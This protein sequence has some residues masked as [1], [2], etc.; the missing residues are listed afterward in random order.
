MTKTVVKSLFMLLVLALPACTGLVTPDVGSDHEFSMQFGGLKR[1]YDVHLPAGYDGKTALPVVIYLHGGGGNISG[2]RND[3]WIETAN[4]N[5]FI[6]VSP[7]GTGELPNRLL[8]WNAGQWAGGACCGWA[9]EHQVDDVGFVLTVIDEVS[10]AYSVDSQRVY[11]TGMSNGAML[12]Y[13]IA[14]EQTDQVAAVAVV[15]SPGIPDGCAPTRPVAVMHIHGTADPCVPYDGGP[16]GGCARNNRTFEAMPAQAMVDTW[17]ELYSCE[18]NPA[19]TYQNGQASCLTYGPCL[20]NTEVR[21][22]TIQGGGHTW[23]DGPQ[24]LPV[25]IIGPT[26]GD[27]GNGQIWEFLSR[28][29]VP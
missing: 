1:R 24:Y 4:A 27:M 3:G 2:S 13:R 23:P 28:F 20:G 25:E 9:Y 14:C 16:G 11:V 19:I 12:A 6:L 21:F 26:N 18:A 15:A 5:K 10:K 8:T 29:K 22:C 7:A 17:R